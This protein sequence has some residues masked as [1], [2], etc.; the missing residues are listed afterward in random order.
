MDERETRYV[1]TRCG[2]RIESGEECICPECGAV[3]CGDCRETDPYCDEYS[4]EIG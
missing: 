3:Y 1:C 2:E 4:A